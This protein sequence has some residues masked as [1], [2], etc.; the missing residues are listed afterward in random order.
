MNS[1]VSALVV[2]SLII[3]FSGCGAA[4]DSGSN[5]KEMS[6]EG[7]SGAR[8]KVHYDCKTPNVLP[9][10][11]RTGFAAPGPSPPSPIFQPGTRECVSGKKK[12]KD[13]SCTQHVWYVSARLAPS[14]SSQAMPPATPFG[15]IACACECVKVDPCGTPETYNHEGEG[16]GVCRH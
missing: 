10:L 12:A 14:N 16:H 2:A 15:V 5:S 4:D 7:Y 9:T 8:I 3:L 6:A 13:E 11:E 1:R